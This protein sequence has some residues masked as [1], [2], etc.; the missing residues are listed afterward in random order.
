MLEGTIASG[1]RPDVEG[2]RAQRGAARVLLQRMRNPAGGTGNREDGLTSTFDHARRGDEGG[3]SEVDVGLWKP[4]PVRF[5][6]DRVGRCQHPSSLRHAWVVGRHCVAQQSQQKRPARIAVSID[7]V[8]K[9]G[10][11]LAASKPIAD[12]ARRLARLVDF[13]EHHLRAE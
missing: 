5:G 6:E 9:A 10:N 2:A 13:G 8:T 4:A 3:E 1:R 11:A 7:E 12:D